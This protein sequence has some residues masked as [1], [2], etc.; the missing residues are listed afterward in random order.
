MQKWQN[1]NPRVPLERGLLELQYLKEN[2]S[3]FFVDVY[4]YAFEIS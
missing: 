4:K 1:H 3:R 2:R